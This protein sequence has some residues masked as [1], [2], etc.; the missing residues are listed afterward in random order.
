MIGHR[1]DN[2][3]LSFVDLDFQDATER[4]IAFLAGLGHRNLAFI[5]GSDALLAAGYGPVVRTKAGF[6]AAVAAH[7]LNAVWVPSALTSRA[8]HDAVR[9]VLRDRPGCSAI[10]TAQTESIGGIIQ[11]VGD[12][13]RSIPRDL[14]FIAITSPAQA[15][16][17]VP[18]VTTLDFPAA[19]M[20][21]LGAELLIRQLQ[22]LEGGE[23]VRDV[24]Q[25]VQRLL[26]A[27]LTIRGSTGPCP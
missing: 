3:G 16:G 6:D 11:A 14:S 15:E 18:A 21:R 26:R 1:A 25:P 17:F 5:G 10:L 13:G 24:V 2:T 4:A 19:E 8:A 7:G 22:T 9:R 23:P 12:A 20:G 27:E